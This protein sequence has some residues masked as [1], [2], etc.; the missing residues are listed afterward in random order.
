MEQQLSRMS[1]TIYQVLHARGVPAEIKRHS[2][3]R[4]W[5]TPPITER[6]ITARRHRHTN[7][8]ALATQR[9]PMPLRAFPA[10]LRPILVAM[11]K[12]RQTRTSCHVFS[13]TFLP[14]CA[15]VMEGVPSSA[16]Y[17]ATGRAFFFHSFRTML[18]YL[19]S[20]TVCC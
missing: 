3:Q 18:A 5:P 9:T 7:A 20:L 15:G 2:D 17:V 8:N 13:G 4:G 6:E 14:T 1:F 19:P 11:K 12:G 16:L 10:E